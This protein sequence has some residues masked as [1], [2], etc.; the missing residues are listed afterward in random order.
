MKDGIYKSETSE[1]RYWVLLGDIGYPI[2]G[3]VNA[4]E[5]FGRGLE[6]YGEN[7]AWRDETI[8]KQ[9]GEHHDYT[10]KGI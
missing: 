3:L 8:T 6:K 4:R 5:I 7:G 2:T 10:S 1:G 9:K